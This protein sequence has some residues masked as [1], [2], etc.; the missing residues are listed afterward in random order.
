MQINKQYIELLKSLTSINP[1]VLILRDGESNVT[2]MLNVT[3]DIF[4]ELVAPKSVFDFSGED[5]GFFAFPEFHDLFSAF[6]DAEVTQ[7]DARKLKIK[8]TETGDS[9]TYATH[10]RLYI[11]GTFKGIDPA[12]TH[13]KFVMSD[14][15]RANIKNRASLISANRINFV[16]NEDDSLKVTMVNSQTENDFSFIIAKTEAHPD[17]GHVID[18]ESGMRTDLSVSFPSGIIAKLPNGDY[19]VEVSNTGLISFILDAEGIELVVRACAIDE[20][21]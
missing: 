9:F 14:K 11:K 10:E 15:M 4:Y 7:L 1:S 6:P 12:D 16:S 17:D 20:G 21:V 8:D 18:D 2:R 3:K 5:I 19:H 13:F